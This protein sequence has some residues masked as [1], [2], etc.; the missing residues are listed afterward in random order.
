[1]TAALGATAAGQHRLQHVKY[2]QRPSPAHDTSMIYILMAWASLQAAKE[3]TLSS[4]Y[5]INV[6]NTRG[7]ST[8]HPQLTPM[9]RNKSSIG[10]PYKASVTRL[11]TG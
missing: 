3:M 10:T 8:R 6:N 9:N 7:A 1:M 11:V 2:E 4:V 5:Q